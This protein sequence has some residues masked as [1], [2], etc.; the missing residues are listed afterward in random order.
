M[1]SIIIYSGEFHWDWFGQQS[2]GTGCYCDQT[3]GDNEEGSAYVLE[4]G[5]K[6]MNNHEAEE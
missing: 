6:I 2:P 5:N 4:G 1:L 3:V